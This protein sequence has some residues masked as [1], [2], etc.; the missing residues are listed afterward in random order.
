MYVYIYPIGAVYIYQYMVSDYNIVLSAEGLMCA[1][2]LRCGQERPLR[3]AFCSLGL[4][5]G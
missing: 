2:S 5:M 3:W 1:F 4:P